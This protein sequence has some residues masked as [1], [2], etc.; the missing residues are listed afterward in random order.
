MVAMAVETESPS[1]SLQIV[2]ERSGLPL[3]TTFHISIARD[4]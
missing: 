3:G 1:E 2:L 4:L